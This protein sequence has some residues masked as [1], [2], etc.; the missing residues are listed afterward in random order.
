MFFSYL[1]YNR[2]NFRIG[3][4]NPKNLYVFRSLESIVKKSKIFWNFV[5]K[6]HLSS[7]YGLTRWVS[8]VNLNASLIAVWRDYNQRAHPCPKNRVSNCVQGWCQWDSFVKKSCHFQRRRKNRRQRDW[9][10]LF[11]LFWHR[12][13]FVCINNLTS[14]LWLKS[15]CIVLLFCRC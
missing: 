14:M 12:K 15:E 10:K 8:L 5:V 7:L 6:K 1:I 11:S 3:G 9:K 4:T 2:L 13:V